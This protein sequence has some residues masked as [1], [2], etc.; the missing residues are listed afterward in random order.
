MPLA[1]AIEYRALSFACCSRRAQYVKNIDYFRIECDIFS[2]SPRQKWELRAH[3]A[4][5]GSFFIL[6]NGVGSLFS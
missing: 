6:K 3:H 5:I 2:V 1:K 4:V